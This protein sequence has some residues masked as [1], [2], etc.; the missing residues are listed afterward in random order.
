M[1]ND[2]W[3]QVREAVKREFGAVESVSAMICTTCG[4]S[5]NQC[6]CDSFDQQLIDCSDCTELRRLITDLTDPDPCSFD[7]HGYCQAHGWFD[8]EPKCPHARAKELI[9][10]GVITR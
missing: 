2:K 9:D 1:T 4:E 7:H 6:G 5:L 3:K 8:V 10:E